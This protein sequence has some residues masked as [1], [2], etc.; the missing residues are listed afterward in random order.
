[1]FRDLQPIMEV[2]CDYSYCIAERCRTD[3]L[4]ELEKQSLDTENYRDVNRTE[5]ILSKFIRGK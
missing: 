2:Y 3:C 4:L 5:N 1:M